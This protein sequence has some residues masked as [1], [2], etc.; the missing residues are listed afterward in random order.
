[1]A[2]KTT[3]GIPLATTLGAMSMSLVFGGL[4][5][6]LV[7][8]MWTNPSREKIRSLET[9]DRSRL[10]DE[11]HKQVV[12]RSAQSTLWLAMGALLV[13]GSLVD[14]L[15]YRTMPVRSVIEVVMLFMIW[16]LSH[17]CDGTSAC[18]SLHTALFCEKRMTR[19]RAQTMRVLLTLTTSLFCLGL[20]GTV[21]QDTAVMGTR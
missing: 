2:N 20:R 7:L 9:G 19:L 6:F 14:M 17:I 1:M 16:Q 21:K 12:M 10:D 8:L 18:R 3:T 15:V 11:R 4:L 13:V 5:T